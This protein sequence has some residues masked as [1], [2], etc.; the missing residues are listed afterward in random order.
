MAETYSTIGEDPGVLPP[1]YVVQTKPACEYRVETNLINQSIKVFLP[2]YESYQ[3]AG[4]GSLRK[5]KPLFPS[6]IFARLDLNLDYYKVKWT[7]GVNKILGDGSYPVPVSEDV[8]QAIR[9]RMGTDN[10]VKLEGEFKEGDPVYI[11]SGPLKDLQGIFIKKMSD[12]G[13]VSILLNTIG[14]GGAPVQVSRYQLKKVA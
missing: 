11:T 3:F 9:T 2:Q 6:Y 14:L 1:W 10:L 5:I 4:S 12:R 13:R 7:R 8:I